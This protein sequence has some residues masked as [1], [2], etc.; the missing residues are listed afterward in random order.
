MGIVTTDMSVSL[1]HIELTR[2][3]V[4]ETD[5]VTHIRFQV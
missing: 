2:S 3:R 1:D 4:V 5:G